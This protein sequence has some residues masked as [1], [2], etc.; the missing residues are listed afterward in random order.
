MAS[1]FKPDIPPE[2]PDIARQRQVEQDRAETSRT[3]ATQEQLRR[4]TSFRNRGTGTR[5][6]LGSLLGKSSLL[7][8]G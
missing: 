1:L 4:E 7:G 6:L 8:S 3:K 5:S 2:N